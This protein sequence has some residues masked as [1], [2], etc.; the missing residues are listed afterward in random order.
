MP[1]CDVRL[2]TK[3]RLGEGLG[4]TDSMMVIL[5][6]RRGPTKERCRDGL[7]AAVAAAAV[8]LLVSFVRVIHMV[9]VALTAIGFLVG[10][11]AGAD[12]GSAPTQVMVWLA[13]VLGGSVLAGRSTVTGSHEAGTHGERLHRG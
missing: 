11:H 4:Q 6:G 13:V 2:G 12:A 10:R 8:C 7:L 9:E 1:A 3:A 5:G